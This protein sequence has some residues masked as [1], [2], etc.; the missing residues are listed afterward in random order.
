MKKNIGYIELILVIIVTIIIIKIFEYKKTI[1]NNIPEAIPTEANI[2]NPSPTP[3]QAKNIVEH[4]P[5]VYNIVG[6][7]SKFVDGKLLFPPSSLG[8]F[9]PGEKGRVILRVIL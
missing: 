2:L 8:P 7:H 9:S 5:K 6:V 1:A 3:V 4:V